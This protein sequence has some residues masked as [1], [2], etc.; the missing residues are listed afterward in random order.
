MIKHFCDGCLE[1]IT[2]RNRAA[3]GHLS[4]QRLGAEIK[5]RGN[6]LLKVEVIT[7]S[8]ETANQGLFCKYCI[9][10]ALYALDDRVL[11]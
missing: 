10:D 11:P 1:E 5:G 2:D 3:G 6:K 9:L 7:S 8:N 4:S